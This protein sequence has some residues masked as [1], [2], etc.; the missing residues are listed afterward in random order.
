MTRKSAWEM[1]DSKTQELSFAFAEKYRQF[2]SANKSERRFITAAVSVARTRNFGELSSFKKLNPGAKIYRVNRGKE[3]VFGIIG[4]K[5]ITEGARFIISH[6]DAPRIDLK[7]KPIYEDEGLCL[8]KTRYYG[9]IKKYH[10]LA[11][12]L[13][14]YGTVAFKNGS[15]KEIAIGDN[16]GDPV[17]AI[18]DLLPHLDKA[19]GKK[20]IDE[21]FPGENL[22]IL[23]GHIGKGTDKENVRKNVLAILK[24]MY[25]IEDEDFISSEFQAV[26]AGFARD[27]GFDRSMI[28][29]YGQDDRVCAY[30]SFISLL[31]VNVPETSIFCIFVDQEEIGS[32]GST[33]ANSTFLHFF[34]QEVLEKQGYTL[35]DIRLVFENSR[36]ISADV[37]SVF[38]PLYRD[39]YDLKNAARLGYGVCIERTTGGKGKSGSTEPSPEYLAHIREIFDRNNVPWQPSELGKVEQG[40][41]GTVATCLARMNISTVDCGTGVLC[42]HA[43]FEITSKADIYSTYLAYR[44]FYQEG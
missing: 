30:T 23:A 21:G 12:P 31:D 10:W 29:G 42:M 34:L 2:I 39:A 36:A 9:G 11:L 17:F 25:G 33:S 35:S 5:P 7:P 20:T 6:V 18:T 4:K 37:S 40:G 43:P 24:N 14:L 16:D 15:T 44:T 27:S 28:I 38:D 22:N 19:Q 32:Q 13:A 3:T 8:M 41:G 26:P 1:W